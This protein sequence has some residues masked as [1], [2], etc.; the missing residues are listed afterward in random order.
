MKNSQNELINHNANPRA[1]HLQPQLPSVCPTVWLHCCRLSAFLAVRA[2]ATLPAKSC[3]KEKF[4]RK[5]AETLKTTSCIRRLPLQRRVAVAAALAKHSATCLVYCNCEVLH[6]RR[7]P[8]GADGC[9]HTPQCKRIPSRP[10]MKLLIM[11]RMLYFSQ[12]GCQPLSSD[13]LYVT[14]WP[15]AHRG[16]DRETERKQGE[17]RERFGEEDKSADQLFKLAA[18]TSFISLAS[19]SE[20]TRA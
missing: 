5:I 2:C 16:S 9:R 4:N 8:A 20:L 11:R 1:R 6:S 15:S 17:E 13:T 7:W 14:C 18:G 10:L 12:F 19:L 3:S